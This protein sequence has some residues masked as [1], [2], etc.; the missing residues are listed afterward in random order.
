MKL[1][2]VDTDNDK[3][4]AIIE[5]NGYLSKEDVQ[6]IIWNVKM[7]IEDYD[8]DDITEAL[9]EKGADIDWIDYNYNDIVEW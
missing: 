4:D 5:T 8:S 2:L 7:T 6:D 3:P 9:E 1:L